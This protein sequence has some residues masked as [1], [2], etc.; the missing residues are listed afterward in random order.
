MLARCLTVPCQNYSSELV[1]GACLIHAPATPSSRLI[2]M[3]CSS[4]AGVSQQR[5]CIRH[6]LLGCVS[7]GGFGEC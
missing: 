1:F 7:L 3:S 6:Q 2:K 4:K 5:S